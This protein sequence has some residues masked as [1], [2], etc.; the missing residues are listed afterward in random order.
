MRLTYLFINVIYFYQCKYIYYNI[1]IF[2][3][4]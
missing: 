4:N 1:Y 2:G 3:E